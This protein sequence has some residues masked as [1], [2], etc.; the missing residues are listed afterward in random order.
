MHSNINPTG[1]IFL[2]TFK[3]AMPLLTNL[4]NLNSVY[5]YEL[6]MI[7]DVNEFQKI[8]SC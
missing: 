5:F 3:F 8:K 6:A 4:L 7:A 1:R 2:L